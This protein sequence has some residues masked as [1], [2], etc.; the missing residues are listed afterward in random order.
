VWISREAAIQR[1][2]RGILF[3]STARPGGTRVAEWC[4]GMSR[5]PP[6]S[7]S[8]AGKVSTRLLLGIGLLAAGVA[9]AAEVVA[10]VSAPNPKEQT[11]LAARHVLAAASAW[12]A[13]NPSG[14]PTVSA[15]IDNGK[16]E[17]SDRVE[18]S[19]GNRFR[20]V[21]E[22]GHATVRSAGPDQKLGTADD[23]RQGL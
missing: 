23:F 21:C 20:L 11:T 9:V 15:L 17:E 14:C 22:E 12:Q 10:R 16:L 19:W 8:G 13:E 2:F 1:D 3:W 7:F 5:N 6:R 18:D 4:V